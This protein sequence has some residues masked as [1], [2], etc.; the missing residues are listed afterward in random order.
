[1]T[2]TTDTIITAQRLDDGAVVFLG[3]AHQW[4]DTPD[5]ALPM[6]R[7]DADVALAWSR[8]PENQLKVVDAYAVP[9][10]ATEGAIVPLKIRERIRVRGPSVRPDLQRTS[11]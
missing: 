11:H 2:V 6:A 5:A 1:M 4:V 10:A 3:P 9:I 8:R 7:A